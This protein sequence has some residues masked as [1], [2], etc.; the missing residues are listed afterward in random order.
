MVLCLGFK[1]YKKLLKL[2]DWKMCFVFLKTFPPWVLRKKTE[3]RKE[4]EKKKEKPLVKKL[5]KK[6]LSW[7]LLQESFVFE[8]IFSLC[9]T[10]MLQDKAEDFLCGG[11]NLWK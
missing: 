7:Y 1:K 2:K 10:R 9:R 8:I 4:K 6:D 11:S 3:T 5:F